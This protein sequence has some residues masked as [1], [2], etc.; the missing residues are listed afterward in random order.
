MS[1]TVRKT[2]ERSRSKDGTVPANEGQIATAAG[3]KALVRRMLGTC[4]ICVDDSGGRGL[5]KE[6]TRKRTRCY[7][8][9]PR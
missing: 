3:E 8:G 9:T 5:E 1:D 4:D 6:S 2:D 7:I